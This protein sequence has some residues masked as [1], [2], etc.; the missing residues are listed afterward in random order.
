MV[1]EHAVFGILVDD[2]LCLTM[3]ILPM[4]VGDKMSGGKQIKGMSSFR[5]QSQLE[6]WICGDVLLIKEALW[7]C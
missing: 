4:N 1:A 6:S 3:L 7:F 5:V 2:P